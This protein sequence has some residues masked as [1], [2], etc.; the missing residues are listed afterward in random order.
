ML[1][2]SSILAS[3]SV[4]ARVSSSVVRPRSD[5]PYEGIVTVHFELSPMASTSYETMKCVVSHPRFIGIFFL[6]A[7]FKRGMGGC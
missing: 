5:R 7:E 1:L 4:F 2:L 6:L 3:A